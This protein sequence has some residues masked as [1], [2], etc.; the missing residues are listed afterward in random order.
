[1]GSAYAPEGWRLMD[2][3]HLRFVQRLMY[4]VKGKCLLKVMKA[5]ARVSS[6]EETSTVKMSLCY[7]PIP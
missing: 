5:C 4:R 3:T 2:Q 7:D 1:M 6:A